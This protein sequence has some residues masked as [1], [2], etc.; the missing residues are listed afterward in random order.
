[1]EEILKK[2]MQRL[3]EEVP[4]LK[5]I[6]LNIGQMMMENP[7]VDYPCALIDVP[8]AEYSDASA[9][10]QVG[11]M[12]L[13]IELFFIVRAPS[14]MAA[15]AQLR[16]QAFAHYSITQKVYRAL[17][18]FSGEYFSKLTRTSAYRN[19]EYYPRGMKLL[20]ECSIKDVTAMAAKIKITPQAGIHIGMA[21]TSE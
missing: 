8:R 18:G 1:M 19:K 2:V 12:V 20:F 5:W 3:K 13:E 7:P 16:E 9:G 17:Q 11:K 21:G 10:M 15:P 4:E 14:S 6:D